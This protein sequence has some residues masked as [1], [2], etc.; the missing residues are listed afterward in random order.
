[1]SEQF[2][3]LLLSFSYKFFEIFLNL[4]FWA[5][6]IWVI[7]SWLIMF[8]VM[9]PDNPGYHFFAQIVRPILLPFRWARIGMLDLSVL[10]AM[11]T[12]DFLGSHLL[13]FIAQLLQN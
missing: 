6:I 2:L 8:R 4:T 7:I 12:I 5:L 13:Q 11:L 1:M 3:Y 10:A 9:R